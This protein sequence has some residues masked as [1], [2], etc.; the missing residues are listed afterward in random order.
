MDKPG[1]R[2]FY[3]KKEDINLL[4][5]LAPSFYPVYTTTQLATFALH[6]GL[7]LL[8]E[9]HGHI[10]EKISSTET[11]TETNEEEK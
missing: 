10:I 11:R 1:D 9:Q 3:I 5:L 2:T 8:M 4:K 7:T 6:L